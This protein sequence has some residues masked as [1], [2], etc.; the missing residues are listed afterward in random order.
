MKIGKFFGTVS[1]PGSIR[2]FCLA[3]KEVRSYC[4]VLFCRST[5]LRTCLFERSTDLVVVEMLRSVASQ[6]HP[7]QGRAGLDR[8]P[9][10]KIAGDYEALLRLLGHLV[11]SK[12][13]SHVFTD[14]EKSC[15]YTNWI[16]WFSIL[17]YRR[18]ESLTCTHDCRSWETSQ[19]GLLRVSK[20]R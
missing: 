9:N 15:I 6:S 12:V 17:V 5:L 7:G 1:P 20:S 2:L 16:S 11:P 10:D 14:N 19:F 18:I 13:D 8:S 3:A 4:F